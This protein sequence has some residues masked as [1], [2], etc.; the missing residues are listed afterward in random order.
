MSASTFFAQSDRAGPTARR[1]TK[2]PDVGRD[3]SDPVAFF[4]S[5]EQRVR[6]NYVAIE[7]AKILREELIHCYRKE[8]VNHIEYCQGIAAKY[9]HAIRG[10]TTDQHPRIPALPIPT[11]GGDDDE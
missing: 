8:G 6:E 10:C 2:V 4:E 3:T 1:F 5:R 7:H 9:K 11:G